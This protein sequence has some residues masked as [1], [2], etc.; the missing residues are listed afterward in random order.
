MSSAL[1]QVNPN[2]DTSKF[3]FLMN[4]KAAVGLSD[5]LRTN[6][7]PKGTLKMLVSGAGDIKLTKD[8]NTLLHQ[9]QI[10]HP[11]ASLIARTA[12]AQDDICGDGESQ[13]G[14]KGFFSF[15]SSNLRS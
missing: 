7:G 14:K 2:A 3:A 9:M 1:Q 6:L 13:K 10:Q 12:T 4:V 15:L 11:T 8:G 5:V